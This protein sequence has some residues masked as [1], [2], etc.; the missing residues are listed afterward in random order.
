MNNYNNYDENVLKKYNL[1]FFTEKEG[2]LD[3]S[4]GSESNDKKEGK[5]DDS[6]ESKLNDKKEG[7]LDDSSKKEKGF[8]RRII[9]KIFRRSS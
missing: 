9:D 5:L 4:K 2:E 7:E 3:D 1:D 6:K 8:F